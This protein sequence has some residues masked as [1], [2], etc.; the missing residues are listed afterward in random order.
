VEC[1]LA[2][3]RCRGLIHTRVGSSDE[4][5]RNLATLPLLAA[6][7]LARSQSRRA[8]EPNVV[9]MD[10]EP[11]TLHPQT[12]DVEKAPGEVASLKE[13]NVELRARLQ[14][15]RDE[16]ACASQDLQRGLQAAQQELHGVRAAH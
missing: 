1:G 12:E 11:S 5:N 8:P 6:P 15:E 13:E 16:Y 2:A 10:V 4:G 14:E 3:C 7:A 9:E